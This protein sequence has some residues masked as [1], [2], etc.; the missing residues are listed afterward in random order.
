MGNLFTLTPAIKGIA[1]QAISDLISQLGKDCK[2]IWPPRA[3]PCQNCL[4]DPIGKK[5][6]NR[7]RT[8]GPVWF[9]D[10]SVCPVCNGVGQLFEEVSKTIT[11]LCAW[12]PKDWFVKVPF[13]IQ[14]P[15]NEIQTKGFIADL[16]S[17]LQAR[18]MRL[19]AS[20]QPLI[21][22]EFDLQGE[23]IDPG[24]IV[25]AK[26]FVARWRRRPS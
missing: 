3:K 11:M 9:P 12:S 21:H 10:G 23:P 5:S 26:F 20:V 4:P 1:Q 19:E 16:P 6:S 2:L 14:V 24:N 13:N 17:V 7:W 25:Q 22:Y 8:G 15:D 18:R